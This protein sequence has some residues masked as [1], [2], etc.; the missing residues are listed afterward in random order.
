M[1]DKSK[2]NDRLYLLAIS[3]IPEIRS[4]LILRLLN[5][6]GSPESVWKAD[7]KLLESVDGLGPATAEYISRERMKIDP[8]P[9][10]EKMQ[11]MGI[12]LITRDDP[13]YPAGLLSIYDPPATLFIKG[14]ILPGDSKAIAIVGSRKAS[15]Y[16]LMTTRWLAG[17]LAR[18]GLTVL[19]G[20]ARGVDSYAHLGA[21]EANGR[22]IAVMGCGL[23]LVYPPENK[24]LKERIEKS[25][26]S[27]SEYPPG[28][29]PLAWHF[30][31]RNRII[32][33]MSL[34]VIIT[35]AGEKS[36]ALITADQ[37]LEQGKEVFAVPG[38]IRIKSHRGTHKLIKEGAKL[39][40][41]VEDVLEELG[42]PLLN[43]IYNEEGKSSLT[44]DEER[45]LK[46][47]DYEEV[48]LEQLLDM[49]GMPVNE[50][51]AILMMLEARGLIQRLP[52]NTY[53]KID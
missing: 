50:V 24:K 46:H 25:G 36:G 2:L 28:T 31:A 15:S 17:E 21:L 45:V 7:K 20:M 18:A 26:A 19:S 3:L 33:G 9:V 16:G 8:L 47:L 37:A 14:K 23:D 41:G 22:T 35:E 12:R 44:P 5:H 49:T 4:D 51:S 38:N 53:I 34:G 10:W 27:I 40:Q 48:E 29:P 30:P 1:E 32:S 52:G 42:I 39:I 43:T 13:E 11:E 6:F